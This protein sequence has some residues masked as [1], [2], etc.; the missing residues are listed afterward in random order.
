VQRQGGQCL[1]HVESAV[2]D[3]LMA[4]R[5]AGEDYRYVSCVS[6]N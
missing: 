2:I 3:R 1:I 6:L 4:M 5:R